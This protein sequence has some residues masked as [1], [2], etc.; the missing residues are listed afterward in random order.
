[1]VVAYE[2]KCNSLNFCF[3]LRNDL[4]N[5]YLKGDRK[6]VGFFFFFCYMN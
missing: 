4:L 6:I 3:L 2:G 1:M 5:W